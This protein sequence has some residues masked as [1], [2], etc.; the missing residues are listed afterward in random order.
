ME[1]TMKVLM[2]IQPPSLADQLKGNPQKAL[3]EKTEETAEKTKQELIEPEQEA[4]NK[5]DLLA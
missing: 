1:F 4:Q 2:T 3:K 5:I